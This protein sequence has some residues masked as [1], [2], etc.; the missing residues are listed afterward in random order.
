MKVYCARTSNEPNVL[1]L[2]DSDDLSSGVFSSCSTADDQSFNVDWSVSTDQTPSCYFE[3]GF[4]Q[5]SAI[6]NAYVCH[7]LI[8]AG[9]RSWRGYMGGRCKRREIKDQRKATGENW[10][11]CCGNQ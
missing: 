4:N 9:C 1:V 8:C 10:T 6:L 5:C 2:K 7:V 11:H 3:G